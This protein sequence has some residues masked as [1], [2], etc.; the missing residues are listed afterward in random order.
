M[1]IN[2]QLN[3]FAP[4]QTERNRSP[5]GDPVD[6]K[7]ID[8]GESDPKGGLSARQLALAKA[9]REKSK[10]LKFKTPPPASEQ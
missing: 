3:L 10:L 4:E 2:P 5:T 6:L 8:K 7:V 1:S 9:L